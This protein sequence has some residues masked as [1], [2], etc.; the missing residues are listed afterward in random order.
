[1]THA[2]A[3]IWLLTLMGIAAFAFGLFIGYI[4]RGNHA[5]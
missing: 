3:P 4:S 2:F 5:Q 1:M